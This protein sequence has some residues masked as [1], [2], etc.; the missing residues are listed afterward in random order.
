MDKKLRLNDFALCY[1]PSKAFMQPG[2]RAKI[3][4]LCHGI[5]CAHAGPVVR[6]AIQKQRLPGTLFCLMGT[7]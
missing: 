3:F 2:F 6:W 1:D 5:S 4:A 7:K